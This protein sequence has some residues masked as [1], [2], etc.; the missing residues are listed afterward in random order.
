ML[1]DLPVIIR[2]IIAIPFSAVPL[3][4]ALVFSDVEPAAD[5]LTPT[6]VVV[7]AL[8]PEAPSAVEVF[9][10]PALSAEVAKSRSE[11]FFSPEGDEVLENETVTTNTFRGVRRAITCEDVAKIKR[12]DTVGHAEQFLGHGKLIR[13]LAHTPET[14]MYQFKNAPATE[15]PQVDKKLIS[16]SGKHIP[17]VILKTTPTAYPYN[18]GLIH[19][20]RILSIEHNC[21]DVPPEGFTPPQ[22]KLMDQGTYYWLLGKNNSCGDN[23]QFDLPPIEQGQPLLAYG[24]GIPETGICPSENL[25]GLRENNLPIPQRISV[26]HS[27][28]NPEGTIVTDTAVATPARLIALA[29]F[30]EYLTDEAPHKETDYVADLWEQDGGPVSL[31]VS[32]KW[33]RLDE[34]QKRESLT[35]IYQKWASLNT[36][37]NTIYVKSYWTSRLGTVSQGYLPSI[38][39]I[40]WEE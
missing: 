22:A 15:H 27:D 17:F 1:K 29:E 14:R 7:Q 10:E 31:T 19:P 9:P 39:R 11:G 2:I 38:P 5:S 13:H 32:R 24:T 4:L 23:R 34:K 3:V 37:S 6:P 26:N 33:R 18:N 40:V 16:P 30:R 25:K 21:D 12:Y 20:P 28:W 35:E 8:P 36:E